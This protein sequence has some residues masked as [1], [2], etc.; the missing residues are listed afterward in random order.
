MNW[1]HSEE[2]K[3]K[4]Q[5][6]LENLETKQVGVVDIVALGGALSCIA[7]PNT[8][9]SFLFLQL[10]YKFKV[11]NKLEQTNINFIQKISW[12]KQRPPFHW[13]QAMHSTTAG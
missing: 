2:N 7:S 5:S 6:Y 3:K 1:L 12:N 8:S 9:F 13:L 4:I 10:K 11:K